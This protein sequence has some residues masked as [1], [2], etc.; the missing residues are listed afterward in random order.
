MVADESQ[1]ALGAL[2]GMAVGDAFGTTLEFTSPAAAPFAPLLGGPHTEITGGGPFGVAPGQTTDD[3]AMAVCIADSLREHGRYVATDVAARYVAWSL[4]TFD[5]GAQ[6]RDALRRV[7]AHE[8][9]RGAGIESWLQGGKRSAGNGSLMRTTP[10]GVFFAHDGEARRR[11][12]VD[13]ALIT[14][15]DPRCVLACAAHN[16]AVSAAVA[17]QADSGRMLAAARAEVHQVVPMLAAHVN[18]A[19]VTSGL[20]A[21]LH[22]LACAEQDD[23]DLYGEELHMLRHEGFVRVALRLSFHCLLHAPSYEAGLV[24]VVNRGGDADTNGAI[25]GALLGARFGVR[26]IPRRFRDAVLAALLDGAPSPFRDLYHPKAMGALA[27]RL[28]PDLT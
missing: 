13:D 16:G 7:A 27:A 2:L 14:H 28:Y 19:S 22:D 12:T 24:D 1:R 5:I 23:P 26:S 17:A 6:T 15:A 25:T 11:A 20:T 21:V 10:I 4:V 9:P 3:T 18:A 8:D